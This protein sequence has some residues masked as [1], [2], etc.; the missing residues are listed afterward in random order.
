MIKSIVLKNFFSFR[1]ITI[2]L[3]RLNV[4]VG[5]NGVGK[6]NFIKSLKLLRATIVDGSL[7]DLI[8]NQWG[9]FDAMCFAEG[10]TEI[11]P[12]IELEYQFDFET[13]HKYGYSFQ[14]P[15]YYKIA[16][17]KVASTQN[18]SLSEMLYTKSSNGG[19]AYWYFKMKDGKG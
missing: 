10:D 14:E 15:I 11:S 7:T 13:L 3:K 16:F 19:C 5:I 2:E 17:K 12:T 4:L 6:S 9:G 1:D 18:Y 8:M